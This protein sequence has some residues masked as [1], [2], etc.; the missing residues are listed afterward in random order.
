MRSRSQA[1]R[2]APV[3]TPPA[4]GAPR[5][6]EWDVA[7]GKPKEETEARASV[8][9]Q[10]TTP[11]PTPAQSQQ[12]AG[13]AFDRIVRAIFDVP[14]PHAV[15]AELRAGLD[16]LRPSRSDYGTLADELGSAEDKAQRAVELQVNAEVALEEFEIDCLVTIGALKARAREQLHAE[17]TKAPTETLLKET[18][19]TMH[20]DEW[21]DVQRRQAQMK[22]AVEAMRSLA[23]RWK[24]RVR[25]LRAFVSTARGA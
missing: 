12:S 4:N 11:P 7:K 16:N 13:A 6:Q 14:D 8:P 24:E 25:D 17:G 22:G 5:L 2:E 21:R 20:A 3:A 23:E 9:Q 19:A 18:A 1:A 15:F 10:A